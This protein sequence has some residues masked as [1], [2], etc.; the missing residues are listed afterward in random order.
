MVEQRAVLKVGEMAVE[1]AA[2]MAV[3]KADETVE[4]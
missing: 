3:S 4:R 2:E 1:M